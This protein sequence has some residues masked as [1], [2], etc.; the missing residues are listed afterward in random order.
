M[1][2][3]GPLMCY[4]YCSEHF[5]SPTLPYPNSEAFPVIFFKCTAAEAK[6]GTFRPKSNLAKKNPHLIFDCLVMTIWR[7]P[8]CVNTK[9][10]QECD[11]FCFCQR[12]EAQTSATKGRK[13]DFLFLF[14]KPGLYQKI[15]GVWWQIV[16]FYFFLNHCQWFLVTF[17]PLDWCACNFELLS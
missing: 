13:S 17:Y 9:K 16:I 10:P 4:V 2:G 15:Q 12:W 11:S 6:M 5:L 1:F 14:K 7:R 8:A 3:D